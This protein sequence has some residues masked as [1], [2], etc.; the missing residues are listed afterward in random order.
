ML[1]ESSFRFRFAQRH[2]RQEFLRVLFQVLDACLQQN[3]TFRPL[4][5]STTVHPSAK[6]LAAYNARIKR[7]VVVVVVASARPGAGV[8]AASCNLCVRG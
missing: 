7:I 3:F 5:S 4:Y 6:F 2:L 1:L 8:E